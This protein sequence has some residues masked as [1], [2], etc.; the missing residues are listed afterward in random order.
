[1]LVYTTGNGQVDGFTLDPSIGEFLLSHPDIKIPD[2]AKIYSCN[3]GYNNLLFDGTRRY[4]DLHKEQHK[5]TAS[6]N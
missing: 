5:R 6:P 4:L 2:K 3:E 1:M